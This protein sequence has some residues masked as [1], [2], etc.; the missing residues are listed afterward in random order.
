V[1]RLMTTGVPLALATNARHALGRRR[2]GGP[3]ALVGA[4]MG[5]DAGSGAGRADAGMGAE[6]GADATRTGAGSRA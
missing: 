1:T 6:A 5:A 3:E 2:R 4:G